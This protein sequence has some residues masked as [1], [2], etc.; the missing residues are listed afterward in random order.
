MTK[1]GLYIQLEAKPGK[2]K[3]VADF[4][5]SALPMV[6]EERETTA[7]F[8]MKTGPSTFGVFD[9]FDSERGREAHLTGRV[10]NALKAKTSDLLAKPPSIE[11]IDVIASKLPH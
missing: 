1:H 4:L 6:E 3:L 10:A 8:A 7:W 2:E 9:A 5:A 11:K